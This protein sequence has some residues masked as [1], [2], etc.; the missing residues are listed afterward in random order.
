MRL[1]PMQMERLAGEEEYAAGRE[2]EEAGSVK[3]GEQDST[4]IRYTV[5]GKPP[6][7]VRR[8][9]RRVTAKRPS[10]AA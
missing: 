4:M 6:R 8:T 10:S 5:A 9:G 7:S 1:N 3:I 2:L